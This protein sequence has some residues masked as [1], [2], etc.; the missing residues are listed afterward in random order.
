MLPSVLAGF[1]NNLSSSIKPGSM[2]A[3]KFNDM[4]DEEIN[5]LSKSF[6]GKINSRIAIIGLISGLITGTISSLLFYF[7]K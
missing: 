2:I 6:I 7:L 3:Q 5:D 1:T 4:T